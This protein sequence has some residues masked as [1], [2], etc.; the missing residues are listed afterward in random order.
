MNEA[1]RQRFIERM[2][3]VLAMDC[4]EDAHL[5]ADNILIEALEALGEEGLIGLWLEGSGHW[6]W[7]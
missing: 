7:A 3:A 1:E 6:R 4:M 2:R 5:E